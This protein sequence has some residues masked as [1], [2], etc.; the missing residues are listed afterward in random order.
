MRRAITSVVSA[1]ML[2]LLTQGNTCLAQG[3]L[4]YGTYRQTCQNVS[5]NGNTLSAR[6]QK[7]D[8]GSRNTSIDY[9]SCR[10]SEI[11]NDNGYLRCGGGGGGGGYGYHG[12]AGGWQGG[13][14]PGDYKRT[15]QNMRINGNQLYANCQKVDGGWNDTSLKNADQCKTRIVNENGNLRCQ[16]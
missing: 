16:K 15:C 2:V 8:G 4:P 12:G 11:I 9:R 6:C 14:P 1:L 7:V 10:G 13:L 3:G 5:V